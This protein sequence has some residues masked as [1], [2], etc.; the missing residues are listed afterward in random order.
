MSRTRDKAAASEGGTV[1]VAPLADGSREGVSERA[2]SGGVSDACASPLADARYVV[3]V[4]RGQ[5]PLTDKYP[6]DDEDQ[7]RQLIEDHTRPTD[8]VWVVSATG[9]R[10]DLEALGIDRRRV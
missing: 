7:V 9:G 10:L 4:G 2:A 5:T 8:A 1:E 3:V 6:A